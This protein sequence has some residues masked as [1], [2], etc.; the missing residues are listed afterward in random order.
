M[1]GFANILFVKYYCV[2]VEKTFDPTLKTN[3]LITRGWKTLVLYVSL[4][5]N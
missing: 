1:K 4:M 5:I 2:H 3:I